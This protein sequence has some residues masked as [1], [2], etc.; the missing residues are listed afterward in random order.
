M[1][2]VIACLLILLTGC[3]IEVDTQG[4]RKFDFKSI[5]VCVQGVVYYSGHDFVAPKFNKES[6]VEACE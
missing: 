1:R 4:R 3:K 2:I 6:K 5:E